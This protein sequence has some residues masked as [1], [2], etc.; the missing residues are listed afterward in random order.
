MLIQ[1]EIR[2]IN[3]SGIIF[4]F[5]FFTSSCS[6]EEYMREIYFSHSIKLDNNLSIKWIAEQRLSPALKKLKC[7]KITR[8]ISIEIKSI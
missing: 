2:Q 3:N 1:C 8:L 7:E 4:K 6:F 5:V